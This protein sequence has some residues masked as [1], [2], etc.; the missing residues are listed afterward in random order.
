M[1]QTELLDRVAATTKR[2]EKLTIL[3]DANESTREFLKLALDPMITFGI[4][5]AEVEKAD[6][7]EMLPGDEW[8]LAVKELAQRLGTR[9]IAGNAAKEAVGVVCQAAPSDSHCMWA[10]RMFNKDLRAGIASGIVLEALPGLFEEFEVFLAKPYDP[11]KH[12]VPAK[13]IFEP[14]LDGLRMVIIEG[15]AYTRNGHVITAVGPVLEVLPGDVRGG[16][17]LDGEILGATF[18]E[19]S[20]QVRQKKGAGQ[21][22]VYNVFDVIDFDGWKAHKTA[23]MVERKK[24]LTEIFSRSYRDNGAFL[25]R[26]KMVPYQ[27]MDNATTEDAFR[28]RD[29][30]L[31]LGYEGLMVKDA[32]AGY[33]WGR[34][35]A[36]FKVKKM[37]T[38]DGRIIGA[39]EGRGKNKGRLGAFEVEFDGVV[40]KV[41]GGFTDEQRQVLWTGRDGFI[42]KMIEC[43]YQNKTKD[44]ALR[45]PVFIKFR[46]DKD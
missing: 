45:F 12:S 3:K 14:K 25:K 41:G 39:I 10:A 35:D 38:A 40:T 21:E 31:A 4:S 42:G 44:G 30:Y 13:A 7:I 5:L 43:Q 16:M 29:Q 17:V 28:K 9:E 18:D 15:T 1:I 6:E 2:N 26:L 27:I 32:L 34:T 36:M 11:D 46:P 33:V 8:W 20:G 19:T 24:V 22:L 37:D 23:P